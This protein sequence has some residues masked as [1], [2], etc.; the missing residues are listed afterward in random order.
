MIS[1]FKHK[2]IQNITISTRNTKMR[3][4][5]FMILSLLNTLCILYLQHVSVQMSQ[6]SNTQ[7]MHMA[8]DN[9]GQKRIIE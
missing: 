6:I 5:L 1:F 2:Y 3:Y 4:F 7:E 8:R 9:T